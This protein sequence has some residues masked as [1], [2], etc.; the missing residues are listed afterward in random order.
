MISLEKIFGLYTVGFLGVTVLI[1]I[2]EAIGLFSNQMI[3]WIFM[4]LS[5]AIYVVI[6]VLTRTSNPDQY[7]VAGRGVPAVFNGMATGSDWMSAASFISMGGALSAQGFAGLAYVMGWTGGYLLLAVFL[8]P[9]LRQFGAYTIPDFLG[10]RFGGNI[11]RLIGV[12][13]AVACS[14]TYLIAQVTGVGLIVARFIGLDFNV[15]VFVG[16]LG[17][18]FCSVLGGMKSVTWTQVA[19][20]IILI[21]SYLVPVVY[22]SWTI[23]S[24]PIPELTYGQLLQQ[25]NARAFEITKDAKEKETRALWQKEADEAN[26]KIKAG[27]LPEAEVE[28]LKTQAATA[29]RQATAPAASETAKFSRYLTVPGGVGMWNFLALTFCLMVGT[30][31]LP[32]ILTRYYTTPSVRQARTSV[33]WSLFFIFLLYFTAPAYAAFARFTIYAKLVGT[34]LAELPRW[35]TLWQPAGLFTV[36]DKNGDGVVQ[37]ADFVIRS[38]DFVVLSMPEIAGLPFVITGLVMAGGL[39]A[40]LSTADGLLLTIAN[41]ISHDLYYNII[42]PRTSLAVRL[43][44]TKILLVVTALIAAYVATYRLAIIVELVAWAF[45][46]AGASFFPALVMGI[47]W[48]RANK[49]GACWGMAVGLGLTAFYM[50]GSRFYGLSWFGTQTIASAIFGLPAGFLTIW[51]V[52]LLTAPPPKEVQDLVVSVRYPKSGQAYRGDPLGRDLARTSH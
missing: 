30:A 19:Q 13:G 31:G 26:A 5:L 38:T 46:L 15:G 4:A 3:G 37:W 20:Y 22:L 48:K 33:A 51:I 24:I 18:L 21:I 27:G 34:K 11:P 40:A 43:T 25:N 52:S 50:I 41:A 45:S 44:I 9:Y 6:G 47:W 2:G 1:G 29:A 49:A 28:K 42:N 23:F 10:A 16:L 36:V 35:V 8:G 17:V 14:F 12:V 39:A 32:H 7:Y